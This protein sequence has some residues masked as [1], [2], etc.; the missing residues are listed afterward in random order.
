ML[1]VVDQTLQDVL[2]AM[3]PLAVLVAGQTFVLFV[4]QIDLS[5]STIMAL[6]S[7]IGALCGMLSV[8]SW[9]R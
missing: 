6:S 7:V 4:G 3:L 8:R 9:S 1:M 2:L 5:V